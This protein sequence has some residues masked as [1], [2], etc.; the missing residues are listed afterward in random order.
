MKSGKQICRKRYI[1]NK[2]TIL[3]QSKKRYHRKVEIQYFINQ[4]LVL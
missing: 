1:K 3:A 2:Q 4:G